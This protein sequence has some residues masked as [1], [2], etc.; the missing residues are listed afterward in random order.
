[1]T[2][3]KNENG[4]LPI[5]PVEGGLASPFPAVACPGGSANVSR[6]PITYVVGLSPGREFLYTTHRESGW[7]CRGQLSSW[8][9][10][11]MTK[12]IVFIGILAAFAVTASAQS[13]PELVSKG[14]A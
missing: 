2:R 1:M 11:S 10:E 8:R 7:P 4:S 5:S 6:R 9:G 12:R 3:C 13:A 14:M